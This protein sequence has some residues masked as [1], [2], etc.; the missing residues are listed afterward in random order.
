MG[1]FSTRFSIDQYV[2]VLPYSDLEETQ[3]VINDMAD[4]LMENGIAQ[5]KRIKLNIPEHQKGVDVNIKSGVA[6]GK[7]QESLE[8]V[9]DSAMENLT[10]IA[11]FK[12]RC[13]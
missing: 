7:P 13:S 6:Q 2:T 1:G 12:G 8:S 11:Q 10:A 4:D 5:I 9:I 3:R